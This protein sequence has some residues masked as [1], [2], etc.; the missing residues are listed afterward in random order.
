MFMPFCLSWSRY[1]AFFSSGGFPAARLG[2]GGG[3]AA[4]RPAVALAQCVERALVDDDRVL[5]QP[6]LR[7]VEVLDVLVDLR[8]VAGRRPTS[9]YESTTPVA[10]AC[11]SSAACTVT[12]CAP[13]SSAMREVA[14]L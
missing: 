8:V 4:P 1:Q 9:S 3:L 6:R 7:V 13:T 14:G 12:G 11:V 10:S 2:V 5:R